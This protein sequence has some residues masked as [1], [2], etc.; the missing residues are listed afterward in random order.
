MPTERMKKMN[1]LKWIFGKSKKEMVVTEKETV[2]EINE[3]FICLRSDP[4]N[5]M[6]DLR[7][8]E[9]HMDKVREGMAMGLTRYAYQSEVEEAKKIGR[10]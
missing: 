7:T 6:N 5:S 4:I 9:W 2:D 10:I 8:G 1:F 3:N